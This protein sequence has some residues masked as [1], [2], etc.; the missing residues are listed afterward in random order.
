VMEVA[1]GVSHY[2]IT[3]NHLAARRQLNFSGDEKN[4]FYFN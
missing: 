2:G 1:D 4:W 3:Q